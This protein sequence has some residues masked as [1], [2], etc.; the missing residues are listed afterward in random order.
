MDYDENYNEG[1]RSFKYS[2]FIT[3]SEILEERIPNSQIKLI[4]FLFPRGSNLYVFSYQ[5]DQRTRYTV[6]DPGDLRYTP[7]IEGLLESKQINISD[8]E[9]IILTHHHADHCGLTKLLADKSNARIIIPESFRE[10]IENGY[11]GWEKSFKKHFDPTELKDKN[12]DY[13][14]EMYKMTL[15]GLDFPVLAEVTMDT[16]NTLIVLGCPESSYMHSRDQQFVLYSINNNFTQGK[17]KIIRAGDDFLF[18]G[19]LWLME[20]P[21]YKPDIKLQ[22][23]FIMRRFAGIIRHRKNSFNAREQ[24]TEAKEALKRAFSLIKVKPGHGKEFIGSRIL[25][26]SIMSKREMQ[27]FSMNPFLQNVG[28]TS[29]NKIADTNYVV[30]HCYKVFKNELIHWKELGHSDSEIVYFLVRIFMEQAGGKSNIK[31]DRQE[32]KE[33][34]IRLLGILGKDSVKYIKLQGIGK[35]TLDYIQHIGRGY[36][37][38]H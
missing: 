33:F 16:S 3:K 14:S 5:S 30:G 21:F 36:Y 38:N 31:R 4:S 1:L 18:S 10:L 8:I 32:R 35:Q 17:N 34:L 9:N 6:I 26:N 22:L 25:P 2:H 20:S 29:V 27:D 37:E 24:D 7:K 15:G 23:N 19:D 13:R 28:D 12:I 11:F